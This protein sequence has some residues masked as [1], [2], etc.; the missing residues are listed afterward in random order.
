MNIIHIASYENACWIEEQVKSFDESDDILTLTGERRQTVLGFG[1]CFN[2]LGWEALELAEEK[3]KD[4]FIKELFSKEECD[5]N[6]GRIPIGGNDFS[7]EWYSCDE[8]E[9]DFELD[10]FTIERDKKYTIPF[11]RKG[12][13]YQPD[14][15][16]FASP[17]SPPIWMKT[18]K[19]YNYGRI[20]MED[21]ILKAYA[22]YFVK[23]VKAYQLEG[24]DI[25][26]VHVQNE[27]MA[28]QKFPSCLWSGE[29]M[30]DFIKDYLGPAFKQS[31]LP[32]E[33][34]LGTING[35]FADFMMPNSAPIS[36]FYDQFANTIL[37]DE[38]ARG[39]LTGVGLQWGGKH[40]MQQI[41]ESFPEMR[42]MQTESECGNGEN[43]WEHME[44][45]FGQM[46]FYFRNGAERYT[47]WNMALKE[48]G[49]STWGWRQ[50][51]LCTVNP[52][53]GQLIKHP[54]FYLMKHLSHFVK[55]GAKVLAT[56]GH[57]TSNTIAFEN[58]D[59]SVILVVGSNMN[60]E[61]VFSFQHGEQS[62]SAVIPAHSIHT[63]CIK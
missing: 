28:D 42:Y 37:S 29:N 1:G 3:Q 12:L 31:G 57:W 34:W 22:Q 19:A 46:W 15:T 43:T 21:K 56:K 5:F 13:E 14:F 49:I 10:Q 39:Y 8:V 27:P 53:T 54:E 6:Y 18:K 44:Y 52:Q 63:F 11:I 32:T 20:R 33:I 45:I 48:G 50:N 9:D 58:T 26:Q 25:S 38:K 30:R 55:K 40:V 2:E 61:R 17:W 7:L 60:R 59:G 41:T 23:F 16:L 4:E 35:P 51:S 47:Y 36:E 62:F 24:I